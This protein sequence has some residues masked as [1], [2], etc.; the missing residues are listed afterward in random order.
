M[1][2]EVL[3]ALTP[4]EYALWR[5]MSQAFAQMNSNPRSRPKN[6]QIDHQE[7]MSP[8]KYVF[9]TPPRGI[10]GLV[11]QE[12]TTGSG[13]GT[14][15]QT[16]HHYIP[17]SVECISW[18]RMIDPEDG[19]ES[20]VEM[21]DVKRVL[22]NL[23]TCRVP[24]NTFITAE[25]DI[26]GTWWVEDTEDCSLETGTGTTGCHDCDDFVEDVRCV[27]NVIVEDKFS[28]CWTVDGRRL[29]RSEEPCSLFVGTFV[30]PPPCSL[31]PPGTD[32]P[33]D[34]IHLSV[35]GTTDSTCD[36]CS[37]LNSDWALTKGPNPCF[38]FSGTFILCSNALEPATYQWSVGLLI[39][40]GSTLTWQAELRNFPGNAL[41]A[42]YEVEATAGCQL[43]YTLSKVSSAAGVCHF[44]DTIVL[45]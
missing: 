23:S 39:T 26:W 16:K 25:M 31:C 3:Y 4:A 14:G 30:P 35:S 32:D 7:M 2:D 21:E 15:T 28:I 43:P 20:L 1:A 19:V 11:V 8:Q 10:P 45:H 12:V 42:Q 22:Y 33:G 29:K 27:G 9:R 13:S 44:P 37:I 18:K 24:G 17:G 40:G 6:E 34:T 41:I 5:R 38:W 36:D